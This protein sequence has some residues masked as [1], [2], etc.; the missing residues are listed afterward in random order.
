MGTEQDTALTRSLYYIIPDLD[1]PITTDRATQITLERAVYLLIQ[2]VNE[3]VS[4]E[5]TGLPNVVAKLAEYNWGDTPFAWR[6][7]RSN[8]RRL[9]G[10]AL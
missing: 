2:H 1:L 6:W 3:F 7:R 9:F 4:D 8:Q 5:I 10:S